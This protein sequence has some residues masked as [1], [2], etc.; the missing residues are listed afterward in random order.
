MVLCRPELSSKYI[1]GKAYALVGFFSYY[2]DFILSNPGA[3]LRSSTPVKAVPEMTIPTAKTVCRSNAA[4]RIQK[5][6][7]ILGI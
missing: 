7:Y 5:K 3:A 4:L 1:K 6:H 2:N